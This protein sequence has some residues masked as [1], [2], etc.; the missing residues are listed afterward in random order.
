MFRKSDLEILHIDIEKHL[1]EL[2]NAIASYIEASDGTEID[3]G[4]FFSIN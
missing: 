4:T 1:A 2:Q 3:S